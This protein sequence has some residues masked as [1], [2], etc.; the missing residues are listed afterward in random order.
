MAPRLI[1]GVHTSKQA[2]LRILIHQ[3]QPVAAYLLGMDLIK[4]NIKP[5]LLYKYF[6]FLSIKSCK[7]VSKAFCKIKVDNINS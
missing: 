2:E 7:T 3:P 1:L 6:S 5:S 4:L